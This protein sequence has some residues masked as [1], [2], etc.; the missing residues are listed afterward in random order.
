MCQARHRAYC[1]SRQ[2]QIDL[3]QSL[4]DCILEHQCFSDDP[5]PLYEKFQTETGRQATVRIRLAGDPGRVTSPPGVSK[6]RPC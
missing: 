5:C 1:E 6:V 3:R 4:G 2:Q